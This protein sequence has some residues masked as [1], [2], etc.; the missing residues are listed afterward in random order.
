MQSEIWNK[1]IHTYKI[2]TLTSFI[3]TGARAWTDREYESAKRYAYRLR[4][5]T[6]QQN[7]SKCA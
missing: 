1:V 5:A 4:L 3:L 7:V 6:R 2:K